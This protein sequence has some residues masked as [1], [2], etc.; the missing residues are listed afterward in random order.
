LEPF[1]PRVV[2]SQIVTLIDDFLRDNPDHLGFPGPLCRRI[3][4]SGFPQNALDHADGDPIDLG[5][6]GTVN[7]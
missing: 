4:S 3:D 7:P 6:L 1:V 2:P 5:D